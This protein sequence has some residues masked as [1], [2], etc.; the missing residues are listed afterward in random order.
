MEGN[1]S[2]GGSVVEK[3]AMMPRQGRGLVL[4]TC[5]ILL[6]SQPIG[7]G[8]KGS[9]AARVETK[10]YVGT[11]PVLASFL[12]A[13]A[14]TAGSAPDPWEKSCLEFKLKPKDRFISFKIED[15]TGQPVYGSV[16]SDGY[17]QGLRTFCGETKQPIPNPG[18]NFIYLEVVAAHT[19]LGCYPS[20]VTHGTVT[21]TFTQKK[22]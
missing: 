12:Y 1:R 22:R 17:N 14:C 21:A 7:A 5:V 6:A 15:A 10:E 18:G 19:E 2:P 16:W 3:G 13:S 11:S 4:L 9:H 20:T 8:A